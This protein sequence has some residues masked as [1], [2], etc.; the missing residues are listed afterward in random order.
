MPNISKIKSGDVFGRLT[1]LGRAPSRNGRT[2]WHCKCE[3]GNE[4][5]V[6]G[7][8]MARTNR[9]GAKSCG[10]LRKELH[11]ERV[12]THGMSHSS[13]FSIWGNILDRCRNPNSHSYANYGGRGITICK[14]WEKFETFYADMGPRPSGHSL[15]RIDNDKGYSKENCRWATAKEQ[16]N[17]RRSNVNLTIGDE[18]KTIAGWSE[19]T[20]VNVNTIQKRLYDGMDIKEAVET[21]VRKWEKTKN[22]SVKNQLFTHDGE[23][24]T[25]SEW[26]KITGIAVSTLHCRITAGWDIS[27]ALTKKMENSDITFDGETLPLTEWA[28]RKGLSPQL[29]RSRVKQGWSIDAAL[30]TPARPLKKK[31]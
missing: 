5:E 1:V 26:A 10:C 22:D 16:N 27:R 4:C 28:K 29:L 18:T 23:E 25:L 15:D 17:N 7:Q 30:N 31:A 12:T 13:E 2:F 11:K 14:E 8:E 24:H 9:P 21:P 6:S 3:C 20:G 19:A